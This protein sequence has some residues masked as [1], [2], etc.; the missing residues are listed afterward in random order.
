MISPELAMAACFCTGTAKARTAPSEPSCTRQ[1]AGLK[2]PL[3]YQQQL[4]AD[5]S[6]RI[7]SS[8][9]GTLL[10]VL[11]VNEVSIYVSNA[12]QRTYCTVIPNIT[13]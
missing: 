8:I 11:K 13:Y 10:P 9:L 4:K 5:L 1:A 7:S 6:A 2:F 12:Y 3:H